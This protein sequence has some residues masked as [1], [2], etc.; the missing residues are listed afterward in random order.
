[1]RGLL[2]IFSTSHHLIGHLRKE[3]DDDS[4]E[5]FI[6][7]EERVRRSSQ[8]SRL[9]SLAYCLCAYFL[10]WWGEE[11]RRLVPVGSTHHFWNNHLTSTGR[12]D[13]RRSGRTGR[14]VFAS[15]FLNFRFCYALLLPI[16]TDNSRIACILGRGDRKSFSRHHTMMQ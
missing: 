1:M 9:R 11:Y 7:C 14:F 12:K 5:G 10:Y 15:F 16:T 8:L 4:F 13:D 3:K 2:L 6:W